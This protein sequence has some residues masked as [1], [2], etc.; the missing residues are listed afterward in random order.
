MM[1]M[2]KSN[3][4]S[5]QVQD[6]ANNSGTIK[7][8]SLNHSRR[9]AVEGPLSKERRS[10]EARQRRASLLVMYIYVMHSVLNVSYVLAQL[11]NTTSYYNYVPWN[12]MH[13]QCHCL[14]CRMK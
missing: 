1:M 10:S 11:L 7:A 2:A 12:D 14:H 4:A 13:L 6:L 8:L 5:Y 9:S 3:I